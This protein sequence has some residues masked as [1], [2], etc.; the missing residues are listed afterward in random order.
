MLTIDDVLSVRHPDPPRWSPDGQYLTFHYNVDGIRELWAAPAGGGEPIRLS[1]PAAG[2]GPWDWSAKGTL[3]FAVK[4]SVWATTPGVEP[5]LLL[6]GPEPVTELKWSPD[7]SLL[8]VVRQGKLSLLGAA[9]A[10]PVL[11]DLCVP[12]EVSPTFH[13]SPDGTHLACGILE[14]RRRDAAVVEAATGRLVWRSETPECEY[15]IAWVGNDRLSIVRISMDSTVREY[16]LV[17]LPGGTEEVLEREESHKGL[18]MEVA[19]VASPDGQAVAYTLM[20][21]GW[22]HVVL[23]DFARESRTLLLPG[24]HEDYGHAYDRPA[25]S[26]T[27]RYVAFSSNKG[28]LQQR[29][30][31]RYD[32]QTGELLQLTV[33]PGTNVNPVWSPGGSQIAYISC[34]P[35]HGAEVAVM[36]AV[37]KDHRRVTQSMPV[38]WNRQSI[39]EPQH[40]TF[41][42]AGGME[43]H[44]DLFLPQGFDPNKRYPALVYVHGG[45][46]RQ[47]RY[48][49]HPL[50]PYAVFYAFNQFM[51]HQGYVVLS[52]D[53]RGG[54]GYGVAYEQANYLQF[55]QAEMDDCVNAALY[56]K[57]L[58]YVDGDRVAIWGLSYGGYMTLAA[59]TKRPEVFALGINIAG[60]WDQEQWAA[61]RAEKDAG[62]PVFFVQRWGG[63][64]GEH[65]A[66]VYQQISPRYFVAGLKA[67]LLN[68]HGTADEAVDFAQLDAIVRDCTE[69]GKDF[70]VAYYPGETHMFSKRKTWE[71]AFRRMVSAFDRY[72]KCDPSHR[73]AAMI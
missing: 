18:K 54:T 3:A 5:V 60:V 6:E 48:G 44:A 29:Q 2:V 66:E 8:G 19:P 13:W 17:S 50:H 40:F 11:R 51:L 23:R 21:D 55:G 36:T 42:S 61:W 71:D 52:V 26:P 69:H 73:P 65:N 30:I 37:G 33:E 22:L 16:V 35:Y 41:P 59:L 20:V 49:W 68:L 46:I 62:Y 24:E 4:G 10:G 72:L 53:Y 12:G 45:P 9:G 57:S 28:A 31:W 58:P 7:G 34:G 64:K 15:G 32:R 56:L 70:A 1:A 39:V 43:I 47:M 14:G 27:G 38:A 25:F 67:P 63:P